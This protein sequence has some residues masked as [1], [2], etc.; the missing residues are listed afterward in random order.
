ML[1]IM[2]RITHRYPDTPTQG[3]VALDEVLRACRGNRNI[4]SVCGLRAADVNANANVN[5]YGT[6]TGAGVGG[7]GRQREHRVKTDTESGMA[8]FIHNFNFSVNT[9]LI[10]R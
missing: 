2:K 4:R 3:P 6:V 1:Y 7:W 9:M 8:G 5:A 10:P